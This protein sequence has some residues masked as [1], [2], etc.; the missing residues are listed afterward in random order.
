MEGMPSAFIADAADTLIRLKVV[1]GASRNAIVGVLG[2]RL[3]L[4]T[5]APPEAGKANKAVCELLSR[6]IGTQVTIESGHG[7]PLKTARVA[8]VAPLQVRVALDLPA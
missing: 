1:P 7:C 3:K 6:A 2:E 8:G 5:S 4:R